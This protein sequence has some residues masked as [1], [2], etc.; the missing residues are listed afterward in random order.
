MKKPYIKKFSK[1]ANFTVWIV[2]GKYI[3]ENLD[4]EFSNYG[5]HY[6]FKFIP[7][8]EFWI[9]KERVPGEEKYYID[10]MLVMNRLMAKGV[11]HDKAVVRADMVEKRERAK[12]HLIKKGYEAKE[13]AEEEIKHIHKKLLKKYSS[14]NIKVWI[15]N[16][17]SVR[18]IFFL[19]FT[20]GGHGFVYPF[21]PKDEIWIDDDVEPN[22]IK[23]ILLH[24]LHERN[25]MKKGWA[26][27]FDEF[28]P[29]EIKKSSETKKIKK[30]AHFDSARLEYYCR[31]HPNETE[32]KI[33]EEIK[34]ASK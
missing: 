15:V 28:T 5:Q 11:E 9:D 33:R 8:N 27:A 29:L 25:L 24:E 12:E 34:K 13:T 19:D 3:R 16:G 22:E 26:Y 21:I 7:E 10:S 1:I 23:F 2:D 20:E 17:E 6:H 32:K 18:D 31:K 14:K 4:E 30:S